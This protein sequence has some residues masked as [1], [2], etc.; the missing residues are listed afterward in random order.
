MAV[1]AE[2]LRGAKWSF[3]LAIVQ[4][5][6]TFTANQGMLRLAGPEVFGV[7]AIQLELLLSTLLFLSREGLRLAVVKM[8]PGTT[9]AESRRAARGTRDTATATSRPNTH[10]SHITCTYHMTCPC[11]D[12]HECERI[13]LTHAHHSN[14]PLLLNVPPDHHNHMTHSHRER[15]VAALAPVAGRFGRG[16]GAGCTVLAWR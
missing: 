10:I 6:V 16:S 15:V 4:R 13:P 11:I 3:V 1:G 12:R 9:P 14:T 7:A 2:I 8:P 5:L